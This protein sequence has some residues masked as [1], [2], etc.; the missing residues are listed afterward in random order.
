MKAKISLAKAS[1]VFAMLLMLALPASAA[2]VIAPHQGDPNLVVGSGET[3]K[4]LYVAG[5]QLTVNA[6]TN[7]DLTAAGGTVAVI[8]K[9]QQELLLAGGNLDVSGA[10]GGTARIAGGNVTVSAPVGGDLV[11]AG[12]NVNLTG[13][14]GVSGDLVVAGGNVII[15]MPVSGNVSVMGG[16]VT[17][18]AKISGAVKVR[19]TRDLNFGS[20][21]EVAGRIDYSGP[22]A[23]QVAGGAKTSQ[24]NYTHWTPGNNGGRLAG[25]L[26]IAFLFKLIAW[27]IAAWVLL[28]LRKKFILS[29]AEDFR[30]SPWQNLGWGFLF[31]VA[32]PIAA[33]LLFV[34]LIG[35][36]LGFILGLAYL[37]TLVIA[38]LI[39]SIVLGYL[40]LRWLSKPSEEPVEWQAILIGVVVWQL[41]GFIP[42][43]GWL[44][45]AIIFLMVIGAGIKRLKINDKN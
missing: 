7:G 1:L 36:Y 9:V 26:T 33:V 13:Q 21:A 14:G 30:A 32:T 8:G 12:G 29:L 40:L 44:V 4:N 5:G 39:S 42:F 17:I 45:M 19:A 24:I 22:Q 11:V 25:L 3:H 31:L 41:L 10:V 18:D 6:D 2:E 16:S 43:L 37:L 20:S 27:L 35:Y 28:R 38:N 34:V 15:N 23:A